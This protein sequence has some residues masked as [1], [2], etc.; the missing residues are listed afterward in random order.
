[1]EVKDK[2]IWPPSLDILLVDY[3][4]DIS[5]LLSPWVIQIN[6]PDNMGEVGTIS[7]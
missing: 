1:L 7:A 4:Y 2:N 3:K 5:F 6:S